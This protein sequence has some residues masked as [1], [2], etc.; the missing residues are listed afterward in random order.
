MLP[1]LC[2]GI[3][4]PQRCVYVCLHVSIGVL[5]PHKGIYMHAS[6]FVQESGILLSHK[7]VCMY[8]CT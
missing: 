1:L 3:K 8:A 6:T 2:R 7:G 5:R 4:A